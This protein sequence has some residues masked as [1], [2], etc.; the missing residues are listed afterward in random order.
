MHYT[1]GTGAGQLDQTMLFHPIC[2]REKTTTCDVGAVAAEACWDSGPE[3]NGNGHG[4]VLYYMPAA[5]FSASTGAQQY[6]RT[7][8]AA[9]LHTF[10]A[11]RNG[12]P[13]NLAW[14]REFHDT[15]GCLP[16]GVNT[17]V[18]GDW[19]GQDDSPDLIPQSI[20]WD[21]W[22]VHGEGNIEMTLV[23]SAADGTVHYTDGTGAGQLD[24]TM[25]F[26][27]ICM[28]EK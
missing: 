16:G 13:W 24:Q 20:G 7:C 8:E 6:Q 26:H 15:Y 25:Q 11:L 3:E 21:A 23:G 18:W 9:G 1:D 10:C 27:P 2:M 5:T 28:R 17:Q 12:N 22:I 19:G 4:F 14:Y